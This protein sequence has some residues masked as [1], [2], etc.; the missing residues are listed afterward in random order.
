MVAEQPE[1]TLALAGR[2][3]W[4]AAPVLARIRA[5]GLEQRV[6]LLDYVDEADLPGLYSAAQAYVFPSLY[7]GFGFTP[8]EAMACGAPVVCSRA[9]SLPEVVGEAAWLVDPHD[10]PGMAAALIGVLRDPARRAEL[11]AR[12]P[13]QIRRFSWA[14]CAE[15]TLAVLHAAAA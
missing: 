9:S 2:R 10:V 8:L 5:L 15:G 13:G 1:I 12:G 11:A 14:R 4:L 7:E 3:G 6:R